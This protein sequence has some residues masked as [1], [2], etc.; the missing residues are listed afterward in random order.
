MLPVDVQQRQPHTGF[1][2]LGELEYQGAQAGAINVGDLVGVQNDI[3]LTGFMQCSQAVPQLQVVVT[4]CERAFEVENAFAF[5]LLDMQLIIT[6]IGAVS[7]LT[8]GRNSTPRL[9]AKSNPT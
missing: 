4:Q 5:A 3:H 7:R 1:A 9:L 8:F 2:Q 6:D